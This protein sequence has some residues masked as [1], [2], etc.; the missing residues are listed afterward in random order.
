MDVSIA[1]FPASFIPSWY[2]RY[3]SADPAVSPRV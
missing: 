1:L 2:Y 3:R